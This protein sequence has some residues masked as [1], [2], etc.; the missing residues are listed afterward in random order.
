MRHNT[1]NIDGRCVVKIIYINNWL[2]AITHKCLS[3]NKIAVYTKIVLFRAIRFLITLRDYGEPDR[4]LI[5]ALLC[6][7][8]K[9]GDIRFQNRNDSVLNV[10]FRQYPKKIF[11]RTYSDFKSS[12]VFT[13]VCSVTLPISMDDDIHLMLTTYH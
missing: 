1:K 8:K 10:L 11:H 5:I 6:Q 3:V 9:Y 12:S 7:A 4:L 2:S 13:K